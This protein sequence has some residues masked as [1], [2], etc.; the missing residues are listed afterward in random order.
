LRT[1][2]DSEGIE[3]KGLNA[4]RIEAVRLSADILRFEP[5]CF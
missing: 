5:Y 2:L 3:L 1:F 4:A